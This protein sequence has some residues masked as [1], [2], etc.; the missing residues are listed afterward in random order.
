MR[1]NKKVRNLGVDAKRQPR[2][3]ALFWCFALSEL[4][5]ASRKTRFASFSRCQIMALYSCCLKIQEGAILD[6]LAKG[7]VAPV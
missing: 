6:D 7:P 1:Q 3:R 5:L 2:D 4:K